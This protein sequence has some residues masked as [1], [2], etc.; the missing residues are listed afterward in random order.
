MQD[1]NAVLLLYVIY[2]DSCSLQRMPLSGS[3]LENSLCCPNTAIMNVDD[4]L[5]PA[6]AI[7]LFFIFFLF[8]INVE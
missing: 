4:V 3:D 7:I 1:L 8:I 2:A 6:I 5:V